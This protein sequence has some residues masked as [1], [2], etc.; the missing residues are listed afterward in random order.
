MA[1]LIKCWLCKCKGLG[2][3]PRDPLKKLGLTA[4]SAI[5]APGRQSQEDSCSQTAC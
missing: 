4:L 2:L 1:E 5:Q 3:D